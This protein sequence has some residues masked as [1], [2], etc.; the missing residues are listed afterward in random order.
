MNSRI[1]SWVDF[2]AALGMIATAAIVVWTKVSAP[3]R[4]PPPPPPGLTVEA[5]PAEPQPLTGARVKGSPTARIGIIEYA[6]LECPACG[7]FV[8]RTYGE[9]MAT[10]VDTGRV[11]FF[12]RHFPLPNHQFARPAS[13]AAHCAGEQGRFWP[14]YERVYRLQ[15]RL[16]EAGL[17]A[18]MRKIGVDMSSWSRCVASDRA[19]EAVDA[20]FEAARGLEIRGTPS[21]LI[22]TIQD[23]GRLRATSR[24]HGAQPFDAFENAIAGAEETLSAIR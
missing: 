5:V 1:R 19:N 3:A 17:R 20:D 16:D 12:L 22:G 13:V 15:P 6:D 4:Q 2:A 24:L 14:F 7:T 23:D 21:F 11:R 10:Y 9:L 18:A 8:Q